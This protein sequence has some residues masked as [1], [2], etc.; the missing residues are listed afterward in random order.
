MQAKVL[1]RRRK[2]LITRPQEQRSGATDARKMTPSRG[3]YRAGILLK[4]ARRY[5]VW[6]I[7]SSAKTGAF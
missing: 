1:E 2:N 3:P 7:K 4:G 6:G 5:Q